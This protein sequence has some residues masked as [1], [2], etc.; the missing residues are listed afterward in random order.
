MQENPLGFFQNLG[1]EEIDI[2]DNLTAL[3]VDFDTD[4]YA[5]ITDDEGNLPESLNQFLIFAFYSAEG[6]YHWS[7]G[8][9]N[10]HAFKDIWSNGATNS[11]KC[12]AIRHYGESKGAE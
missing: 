5:L 8:F 9:K 4:G 10:A 11:Q 7:V 12:D 3:A 1:F 2:E 6:A